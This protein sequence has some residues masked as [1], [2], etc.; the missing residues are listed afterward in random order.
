MKRSAWA[1]SM[2]KRSDRLIFC[3]LLLLETRHSIKLVFEMW[4]YLTHFKIISFPYPF[5]LLTSAQRILYYFLYI[6]SFIYLLFKYDLYFLLHVLS[7]FISV[8]LPFLPLQV[9]L[10]SVSLVFFFFF[11]PWLHVNKYDR[12][13][14]LK[15]KLGW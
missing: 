4:K 3:R 14:F 2:F 7:F 12:H 5:L 6:Q 10:L 1:L 13:V 15:K 9:F 8:C 11:L